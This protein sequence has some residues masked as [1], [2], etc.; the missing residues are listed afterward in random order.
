[1]LQI[2]LLPDQLGD[3][4]GLNYQFKTG[5]IAA[6]SHF[7]F[8]FHM[9]TSSQCIFVYAKSG[10][11][12]APNWMKCNFQ[13]GADY[14]PWIQFFVKELNCAITGSIGIDQQYIF[15]VHNHI[16]HFLMKFFDNWTVSCI[17]S[18]I[19]LFSVFTIRLFIL[20]LN[21]AYFRAY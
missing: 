5:E 9:L 19:A 15:I 14:R 11:T 20:L 10:H 3:S 8:I 7:Q 21:C 2:L 1:M 18:E 12:V 17:P 16:K 6:G 4:P 13:F